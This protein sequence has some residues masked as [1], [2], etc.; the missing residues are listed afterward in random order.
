[1]NTLYVVI[2]KTFAKPNFEEAAIGMLYLIWGFGDLIG[3]VVAG[4]LLLYFGSNI[5]FVPIAFSV[6]R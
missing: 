4:E 6:H 2:I 5:Q 1:M 3:G